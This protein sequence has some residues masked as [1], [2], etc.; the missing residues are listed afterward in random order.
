M[1][2]TKD[3]LHCSA[4]HDQ[5]TKLQLHPAIRVEIDWTCRDRDRAK[6]GICASSSTTRSEKIAARL[7][8]RALSIAPA[9]ARI[10]VVSSVPAPGSGRGWGSPIL[11]RVAH[12]TLSERGP[13]LPPPR[14]SSPPGHRGPEACP[15]RRGS[16]RRRRAGR[17]GKGSSDREERGG[18]PAAKEGYFVKYQVRVGGFTKIFGSRLLISIQ[19]RG[20]CE[21][22]V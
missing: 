14:F 3:K 20:F 10:S 13:S 4:R 21:H 8:P 9:D 19:M 22:F 15:R 5:G 6:D 1:V 7:P 2:R 17:G 11:H 16:R 18:L 12:R